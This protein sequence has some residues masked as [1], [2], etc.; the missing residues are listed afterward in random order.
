MKFN[1][2]SSMLVLIFVSIS[3]LCACDRREIGPQIESK[4][5]A[6]GETVGFTEEIADAGLSISFKTK[7]LQKESN[8]LIADASVKNTSRTPVVMRNIDDSCE[9][10]VMED[11]LRVSPRTYGA[12]GLTFDPTF[13]DEY[14]SLAPG[15]N[16]TIHLS[17][18]KLLRNEG[19][20]MNSVDISSGEYP[21]SVSCI[22]EFKRSE[23]V[24][25]SMTGYVSKSV[26]V[27]LEP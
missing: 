21:V 10:V 23:D 11:G 3:N 18:R 26:R 27:T 12:R 7:S 15:R 22:L 25:F 9:L 6:A 8:G 19:G 2:R 20:R 1:L 17:V 16:V 13:K 24:S 14:R 4:R 5:D